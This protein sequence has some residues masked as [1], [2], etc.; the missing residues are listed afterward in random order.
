MAELRG[1]IVDM[2]RDDHPMSVR[3][4]FYQLV[5]R[6]VIAKTENEYKSTVCR[7]LVEMRR[8]GEIPYDWIADNTRWQR[9]PPT[10]DSLGDLLTNVSK[11][12]RRSLWT[13]AAERVEVW[14]EK[15][16]LA[17]VVL[18]VTAAWDVPLLVTRG[19]PSISYVYEAADHAISDGRPLVLYYLG[20]HDPSGV[21]IERFVHTEFVR[22]DVANF[23]IRRLAVLAEQIAEW[24]LPTRPTKRSDTRA[25]AFEG[26]SVELD[27]LSPAVLRGLVK[28][29]ITRHL[30]PEVLART[31][32]IER[33]ER[34]TLAKYA[35]ALGNG[36][37][38]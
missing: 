22:H 33:A 28:E 20:D 1:A 7:L 3:Q 32:V 11:T 2:L 6:R 25:A 12:Y 16:A 23:E 15:E 5:T 9:R 18:S 34:E 27:A 26:Q 30:D 17:G 38:P 36:G 4:V 29:A 13:G 19:Y 31:R 24:D 37:A 10:W 35:A 14:I 8:S 21:D